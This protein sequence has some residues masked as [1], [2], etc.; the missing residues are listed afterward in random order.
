MPNNDDYK[1]LEKKHYPVT[2]DIVDGDIL[3]TDYHGVK[4]PKTHEIY[5]IEEDFIFQQIADYRIFTGEINC[6]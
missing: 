3:I 1:E 4:L 5:T 6:P 2:W